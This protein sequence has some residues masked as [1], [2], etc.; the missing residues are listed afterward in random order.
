MIGLSPTGLKYIV[1]WPKTSPWGTPKWM[2]LSLELAPE[3]LTR[4]FR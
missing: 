4:L 3:I 1:R 2:T